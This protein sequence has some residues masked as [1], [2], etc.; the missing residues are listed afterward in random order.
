MKASTTVQRSNAHCVELSASQVGKDK[1]AIKS[2]DN[3]AMER[4]RRLHEN[5]SLHGKTASVNDTR[6]NAELSPSERRDN[7]SGELDEQDPVD[8]VDLLIEKYNDMADHDQHWDF[9]EMSEDDLTSV[10]TAYMLEARYSPTFINT[11]A[12]DNVRDVNPG[13]ELPPARKW[14]Y[15]STFASIWWRSQHPDGEKVPPKDWKQEWSG[16]FDEMRKPS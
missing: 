13:F 10:A 6:T 4:L 15:I 5:D 16:L 8:D 14:D 2:V 1:S 7:F 12:A 3:W 9:E 11:K